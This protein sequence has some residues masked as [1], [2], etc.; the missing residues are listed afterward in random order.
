MKPIRHNPVGGGVSKENLD[1]FIKSMV[2]KSNKVPRNV[3][4]YKN[5][6]RDGE[7]ETLNVHFTS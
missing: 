6:R 4:K 2:G 5:F 7:G 3:R 1:F